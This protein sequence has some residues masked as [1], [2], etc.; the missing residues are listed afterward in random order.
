MFSDWCVLHVID[1]KSDMITF[2]LTNCGSDTQ[3]H[4]KC[5]APEELFFLARNP[6]VH[7]CSSPECGDVYRGQNTESIFF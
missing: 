3:D 2:A 7:D 1:E 4:K 5:D 6:E